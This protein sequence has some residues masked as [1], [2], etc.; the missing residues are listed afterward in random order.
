MFIKRSNIHYYDVNSLY[1]FAMLQAMPHKLLH[2]VKS[3]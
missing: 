1:P 3:I 2:K